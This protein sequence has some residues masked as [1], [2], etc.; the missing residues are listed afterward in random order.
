ML[1]IEHGANPKLRNLRGDTALQWFMFPR[2]SKT[3]S[4]CRNAREA[5]PG[6]VDDGQQSLE[7]RSC[8]TMSTSALA[9][10]IVPN[11][12]VGSCSLPARNSHEVEGNS[13]RESE[14]NDG[15]LVRVAAL[16]RRT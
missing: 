16:T 4:V 10:A 3:A 2:M 14:E 6:L 13:V 5:Q 1:L 8:Q 7:L 12:I 15:T 9:T 11:N